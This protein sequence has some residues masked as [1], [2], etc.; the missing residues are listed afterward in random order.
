MF[1]N[2]SKL[3]CKG[4]SLNAKVLSHI[5]PHFKSNCSLVQNSYCYTHQSW[6]PCQRPGPHVNFLSDV[7]VME[8]QSFLLCLSC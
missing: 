5:P 1:N 6:R 3:C 7:K 8:F 4:K 2:Q